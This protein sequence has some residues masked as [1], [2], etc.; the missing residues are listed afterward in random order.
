MR[1]RQLLTLLLFFIALPALGQK[2]FVDYDSATAFSEYKTFKYHD[3]WEDLRDTAPALHNRVVEELRRYAR[4]GGLEEVESDP[5]L[6]MVYYA[7]D[8]GDLR[9]ALSDLAYAYGSDFSPGGYW[10]G[11]VGTRT[12]DG[13][14][15]REGTLIIDVWDAADER[16]VWRGMATAAISK[17]PDKNEKKVMTALEKIVKEWE[18]MRGGYI[19]KLRQHKAEQE[20]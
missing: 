1:T 4:E 19:R 3:T 13:F 7:A 14:T 18:Q 17:K 5:D 2:V 11:G 15:F 9:I 12:P 20:Q 10:E 16:L 8:R 6:Y